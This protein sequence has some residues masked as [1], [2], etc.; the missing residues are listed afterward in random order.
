MKKRAIGMVLLAVVTSL[1]AAPPKSVAIEL[2]VGT[3]REGNN[4]TEPRPAESRY[5]RTKIAGFQIIQGFAGY[6]VFIDVI[7]RPKK[8]A[9]TRVILENP[10]EPKKP[11]VYEHYV[12]PDTPTI[13]L[14]H[15]PAKG[16]EIYKDYH[17][18]VILFADEA[19]AQEVDRL[20]QK[21]RSYV[22]TTG[23]NLKLFGGLKTKATDGLTERLAQPPTKK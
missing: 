11:F 19:R 12:D 21:V 22:D 10:A 3:Y 23:Q 9:Y 13:T 1:G 17:V 18:E 6:K 16:L 14:T 7:E 15:G 2:V 5:F 8:R 4:V 20:V